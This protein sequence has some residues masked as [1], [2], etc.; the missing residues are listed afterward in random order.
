MTANGL[1][2]LIRM[3]ARRRPFRPYVIELIT[4]EELVVRHPEAVAMMR[5]APAVYTDTAG[6]KHYFDPDA[7]CQ[8]FRLATG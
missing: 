3:P 4:R 5:V 1:R 8:V 2:R 6:G 7:V